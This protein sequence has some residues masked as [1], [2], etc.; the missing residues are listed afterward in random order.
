VTCRDISKRR[1]KG[2]VHCHTAMSYDGSIPLDVLCQILTEEG[3]SFVAVTDHA[4][5]VTAD[6]YRSF[7]DLC[8]KLSSDSF[9]VIP[10]LEVLL[11]NGDEIAAV[12]IHEYISST[13]ARNVLEQILQ[14]GGYSIWVHPHKRERANLDRYDCDAIEVLNGKM[15][16]S[17]APNFYL[18][19]HIRRLQCDGKKIHQMFGADLHNLEEPRSVWT[20]CDV[21]SISETEILKTLHAGSYTN[22]A[23]R[24]NIPSHKKS[25]F[26]NTLTVLLYR[27]AYLSWNSFLRAM[28]ESVRNYVIRFSRRIVSVIKSAR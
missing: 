25:L 13:S 19:F 16:G 12:G 6:Q 23:S 26:A 18:F 11:D 1:I 9:V 14:Q 3:F 10:G 17:V 22:H 8:Q 21:D 24:V 5:G 4:K 2:I 15:D 28:P 7:V 27:F 20:E